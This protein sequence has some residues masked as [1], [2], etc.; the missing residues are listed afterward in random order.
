ME[1]ASTS[2]KHRVRALIPAALL[3]VV[4]MTNR[5]V[6]TQTDLSPWELGGFGMFSTNDAPQHRVLRLTAATEAGATVALEPGRNTREAI[7]ELLVFP[8]EGRSNSLAESLRRRRWIVEGDEAVVGG[9]G[10]RLNNVEVVVGRIAFDADTQEIVFE[11]L[12][13]GQAP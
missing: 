4:A 11:E 10:V 7:D 5:V 2:P 8:T 12:V 1:P 6:V 3:L 9:G 13:R